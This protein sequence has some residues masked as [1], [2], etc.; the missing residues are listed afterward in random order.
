M[1]QT[2][3]TYPELSD[4]VRKTIRTTRRPKPKKK[5]TR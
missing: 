2:S 4:G 1:A 3:G 5:P